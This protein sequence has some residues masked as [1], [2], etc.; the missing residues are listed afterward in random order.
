MLVDIC[1]RAHLSINSLL[2]CVF[3]D[4][5]SL[6]NSASL[7]EGLRQLSHYSWIGRRQCCLVVVSDVWEKFSNNP[8]FLFSA[9]LTRYWA[10]LY[11]IIIIAIHHV[12]DYTSY[13]KVLFAFPAQT[14]LHPFEIC[15]ATINHHHQ[16][17]R[18]HHHH[19]HRHHNHHHQAPAFSGILIPGF[20]GRDF[21][22]IPGSRDIS[23]RD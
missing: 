9:D 21:S 8:V 13:S 23:G 17:D 14:I 2:G 1:G 12:L 10:N 22:K 16:H 6:E 20:S 18:N 15:Y 5:K 11:K 7:S 4:L 3:I 19:S